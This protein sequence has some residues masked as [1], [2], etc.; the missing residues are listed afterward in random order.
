MYGFIIF[1]NLRN[2][3]SEQKELQFISNIHEY[4]QRLP[5]PTCG[6]KEFIVGA[7]YGPNSSCL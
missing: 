7:G 6:R 5:D 1:W 2:I 3:S 4:L